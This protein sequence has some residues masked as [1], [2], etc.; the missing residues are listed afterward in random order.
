MNQSNKDFKKKLYQICLFHTDL[1]TFYSYQSLHNN[2]LITLLNHIH[3]H[4]LKHTEFVSS[5][6]YAHFSIIQTYLN[7]QRISASSKSQEHSTLQLYL[8]NHSKI[9]NHNNINGTQFCPT[10]QLNP[11]IF[12]I[13][14][15][16]HHYHEKTH[17]ILTILHKKTLFTNLK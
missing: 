5:K 9:D 14:L 17:S 10:Q 15:H 8:K 7:K 16:Q 4:T 6:R 13:T 3:P 1:A 2:S 12:Q 11:S